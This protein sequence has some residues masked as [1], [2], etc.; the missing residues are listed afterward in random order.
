[1]NRPCSHLVHSR[2]ST[3]H[4]F[5][6]CCD[7][8]DLDLSIAFTY[9]YFLHRWPGL[10]ILA[11]PN[12]D[13]ASKERKPIGCVV[14]KIDLGE[15][16]SDEQLTYKTLDEAISNKKIQPKR[17]HALAVYVGVVTLVTLFYSL[18]ISM[19]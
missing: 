18:S 9:R 3:Y 8:S 11:V 13:D 17:N 10:C 15:D 6:S 14:C 2:F 12:E 16:D 4:L 5:R 1:M 7:V 19:M